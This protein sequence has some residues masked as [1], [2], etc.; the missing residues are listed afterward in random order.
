VPP[1][2]TYEGSVTDL[3]H[4]CGIATLPAP[5]ILGV[6]RARRHSYSF[7]GTL[8]IPI[9]HPDLVLLGDIIIKV[10]ALGLLVEGMD[11]RE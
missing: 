10:E 2:A 8:S 5:L 1:I 11:A 7:I 6:A 4:R 3:W 9:R